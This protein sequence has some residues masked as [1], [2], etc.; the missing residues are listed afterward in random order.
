MK[1]LE[2]LV[3]LIDKTI[4]ETADA[5]KRVEIE[6]FYR[7]KENL[8]DIPS[9]LYFNPIF[10]PRFERE[11]KPDILWIYPRM[12]ILII[13]VKAWDKE[14]IERLRLQD[15][16]FHSETKSFENPIREASRFKEGLMNYIK[17]KLNVKQL[18]LAVE[19]AIYFPKLTR[20]EYRELK[21][22]WFREL[23]FEECCIFKKDRNIARKLIE[24]LRKYRLK[25][26]EKDVLALRRFLFPGLTVSKLDLR[27]REKEVPL[28][29]VYQESLLYKYSR[30]YRILRGTAGSGKTVVL[31]G[32]AVQEKVMNKSKKVLIVTFANSLASEIKNSIERVLETEDT[33]NVTVDDFEV[34]TIDSL[35]QNLVSRYVGNNKKVINNKKTRK[36]LADY[37]EKNPS[38]I[39]DDAKYDVILCDE[40]QDFSKELFSVIRSLS[41]ENGLI[42]FGVD[43]TQRIY[44]GTDWKWI[45][46]GFDTRGRGKVTILRKSYRNPGKIFKLAVEFLRQDSQLMKDLKELDAVVVDEGIESIRKDDGEVEFYETNNE[47]EKVAEIVAD[48][49]EKGTNFGDIFILASLEDHVKLFYRA[50]LSRIPHLKSKLHYFS[51]HSPK[52]YKFVPDDKIVIMPYKSAKG[53]ERPI[54]IVTGIGN[55]P[56]DSSKKVTEQRR[57][58]RTLYVALTRA[59][60][61]L[62]I[63]S[64]KEK[65]N[66]FT[67]DIRSILEKIS[68]RKEI[69]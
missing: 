66:G 35:V 47:F 36:T 2:S 61:K 51:S 41:K 34:T 8:K 46:V 3:E 45:D 52:R 54:V 22:E 7:L 28:M 67:K 4:E 12:G 11:I 65:D 62:I 30:G 1:S 27:V 64:Y 25:P 42:I 17:S 63:T 31:V 39:P 53:L 44:D 19:Y 56:Y 33:D 29:D 50:I 24:R 26:R 59:Q 5:N 13:E 48:L 57:D 55:L 14:F 15:E 32:K 10:V 60:K 23:V 68:Y 40:S 6:A 43:E 18:P 69:N 38:L 58:R 21:N 20:K 37:L 16:R 49:I 9:I